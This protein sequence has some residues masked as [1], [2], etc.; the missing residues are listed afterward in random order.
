MKVTTIVLLLAAVVSAVITLVYPNPVSLAIG[1]GGALLAAVSLGIE[2]LFRKTGLSL[3]QMFAA[4]LDFMGVMLAFS[5]FGL[6][7][8]GEH[9]GIGRQ[10]ASILLGV[11]GVGLIA[12]GTRRRRSHL[13]ATTMAAGLDTMAATA[14]GTPKVARPSMKDVDCPG[15][16][17]K[18]RTNADRRLCIHCD[19]NIE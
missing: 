2:R 16:G 14:S 15:C 9:P 17:R 11:V 6:F 13:S 7:T 19:A 10:S 5:S 8:R 12:L 18:Y 1:V 3:K 4:N